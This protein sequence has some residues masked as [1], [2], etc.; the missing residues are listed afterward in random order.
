M[1]MNDRTKNDRWTEG[2][3]KMYFTISCMYIVTPCLT[4][5][6]HDVSQIFFCQLIALNQTAYEVQTKQI[7]EEDNTIFSIL[8]A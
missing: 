3:L 5:G 6:L 4:Y 1:N 8:Y 2:E 7:L